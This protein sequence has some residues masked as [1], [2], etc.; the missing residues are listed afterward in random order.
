MIA[1]DVSQLVV[2]TVC[3]LHESVMGRVKV[4][5]AH[6]CGTES[7][8]CTVVTPMGGPERGFVMLPE[9][10]DDVLVG[11][12][13]G[14]P[15]R[16]YVL[17]SLWSQKQ[18]IPAGDGRPRENNLRFIRSRC[19]HVVRLDDTK[20]KEK[21]EI[22][23]HLGEH[24]IVIDSAAKKIEIICTSGD[25][26]ITAKAGKVAVEASEVSMKSSGAINIEAAGPMNLKGATVNIN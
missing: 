18:K 1:E 15:N 12:E 20:G 3:K 10:G 9:V 5:F 14:D 16:G 26:S 24:K 6:L 17:G 2:G 23:D 7:D 11:F 21:I 22:I 13:H 19:G 8:W 25:V 4:K